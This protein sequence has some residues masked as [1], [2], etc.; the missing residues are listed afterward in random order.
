MKDEDENMQLL[1]T[2]SYLIIA[3]LK[4]IFITESSIF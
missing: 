4:M 1:S 2:P 3:I